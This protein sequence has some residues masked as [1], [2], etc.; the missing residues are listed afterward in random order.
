MPPGGAGLSGGWEGLG[1]LNCKPCEGRDCR[2]GEGRSCGGLGWAGL[3]GPLRRG[4]CVS[5]RR[6]ASGLAREG[7]SC[8]DWRGLGLRDLTK[9]ETQ[10]TVQS[11]TSEL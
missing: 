10:I 5:L 11:R 8:Q 4:E 6:G 7:Q 2:P 3:K 9:A 1:G